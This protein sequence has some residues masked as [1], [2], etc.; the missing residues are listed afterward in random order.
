MSA[1]QTVRIRYRLPGGQYKTW[2]VDADRLLDNEETLRAHL[3]RYVPDAR[4]LGYV[5]IGKTKEAKA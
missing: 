1:I 4:W 2:L 5:W 3:K